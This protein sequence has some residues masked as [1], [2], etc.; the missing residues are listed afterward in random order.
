MSNGGSY[1]TW[2]YQNNLKF[3]PRNQWFQPVLELQK[4]L[5]ALRRELFAHPQFKAMVDAERERLKHE[6]SK[7]EFGIEA[8]LMSRIVQT[9][10]NEV[11]GIVDRVFFDLGWDT[12]AL[13][14][15][16]LIAE[17]SSRSQNPAALH[18]KDGALDKA[19]KACKERGWDIKLAEKPLHWLQGDTP[20]SVLAA[21]DAL[22]KFASWEQQLGGYHA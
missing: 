4:E 11:L 22:Q 7:T 18:G 19:E 9:C 15:D 6:T 1:R 5:I 14:F 16:G 13:I 21:R 10:E 2:L 12:L 20:R 17:P 3:I 8:S